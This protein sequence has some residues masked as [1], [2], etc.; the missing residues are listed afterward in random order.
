MRI[1][2]LL[3]VASAAHAQINTERLR[4]SVEG[5]GVY[6]SLDAS[7]A[8]ATGNTEYLR[9]GLGGRTDV[10]LG[11]DLAFVVGRFDLSQADGKAFLDRSFLHARYNH[12]LAP[13][14]MLETFAQ[15]ERNRQQRLVSRTLFGV[16]ARYQLVDRDS[17]GLAV[18]VTPMFEHEEL[19]AE[20]G[21][22]QSGVLRVSSYVSGQWTVNAATA[23]STTTYVQ[24]RVD[25]AGDLR[26]LNQT[27]LSVG[28]TRWVRLRVQTNLRYD[29]RPPA[30]VERNDFSI[31]NGLVLVVPVR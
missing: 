11:E 19:D 15:V 12:A 27:A 6:L 2:L 5:D 17:L 23:I 22:D 7:A 14:L 3:L 25:D 10:R 9:L 28:L 26:V 21:E 20:L 1:L 24:P 8:Y 16:G 4:R 13:R 29:S 18:G 31:E 30:G